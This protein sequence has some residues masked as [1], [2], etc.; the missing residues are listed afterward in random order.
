MPAE[1]AV[2]HW[3]NIQHRLGPNPAG[4]SMVDGPTES[5]HPEATRANRDLVRSFTHDVLIGR[6]FENLPNYFD[7]GR[8]VQHNPMID[9]GIAAL[10]GLIEA[11][12]GNPPVLEYERNHRVLA[13]GNFVLSVSEGR[14][15]G[16]TRGH[17]RPVP[18]CR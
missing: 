11:G 13:E 2:E 7:N 8:L 16:P 17:L 3:D 9:D 10:R 12:G 18:G 4:R 15:T 1:R 6:R 14:A 5:T